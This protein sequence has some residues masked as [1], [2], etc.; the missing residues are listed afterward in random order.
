LSIRRG[1]L[2][3]ELHKFPSEFHAFIFR[4]FLK[5]RIDVQYIVFANDSCLGR[6]KEKI[7]PNSCSEGIEGRGSGY[8]NTLILN[9]VVRGRCVVN[10]TL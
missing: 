9:L 8:I 3:E 1:D 7:Y 4:T 10:F 5:K 2:N 6:G